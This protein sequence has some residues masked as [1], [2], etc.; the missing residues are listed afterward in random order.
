MFNV[1]VLLLDDALK[2]ATPLTNGA[3][4]ES[5]LIFDEVKAYKNYAKFLWPPRCLFLVLQIQRG[6]LYSL[7]CKNLNVKTIKVSS[8]TS[9][10]AGTEQVLE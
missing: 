7:K 1:S 9:H 2:P 6:T 4:S 10:C 8:M 5:Q 3:I